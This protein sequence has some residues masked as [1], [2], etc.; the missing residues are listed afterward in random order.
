MK[1]ELRLHERLVRVRVPEVLEDIA[2]T[3]LDFDFSFR[4]VRFHWRFLVL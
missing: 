2:A 3:F 4:R 1:G